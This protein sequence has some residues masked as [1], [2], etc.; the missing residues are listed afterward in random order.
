MGNIINYCWSHFFFIFY[1]SFDFLPTLF[2]CNAI[3]AESHWRGAV[4]IF[5][6]VLLLLLRLPTIQAILLPDNESP[7]VAYDPVVKQTTTASNPV[8]TRYKRRPAIDFTTDR[9][10]SYCFGWQWRFL[11]QRRIIK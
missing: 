3:N 10:V 1:I 7:V 9:K 5:G 6:G 2:L 8:Y 4:K 11:R